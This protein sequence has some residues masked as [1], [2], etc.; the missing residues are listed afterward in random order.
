MGALAGTLAA[1]AAA[2]AAT[3][4]VIAGPPVTERP[5]GLPRDAD[6]NAFYR[7]NVTIHVGDRVR[8]EI[9][10]FHTVTIPARGS[11][12][13]GFIVPDPANPVSG[14]NDAG[15]SPFW[16]NGLPRLVVNPLV[17]AKQGGGTY[18]GRRL[19]N[20]GLPPQEGRTPPYVVRFPQRGTFRY[21]CAIHTGNPD[22]RGTVRVV[23]KRRAIPSAAEDRAAA[24][25]QFRRALARLRTDARFRGPSGNRVA[26][27]VDTTNTTLLRFR[28]AVK[29]VR[30]G[31]TLTFSMSAL[32]RA[33]IAPA[34]DGA[35]LLN[36]IA[37]F[38]SEPPPV[39]P[40]FQGTEHGNGYFNTGLIDRDPR[41]PSG[42]SARVTFARPGT[43][44][45]ICL[46]HPDTMKAQ[47][48]V[49]P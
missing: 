49:T 19:L 2:E 24:R 37:G 10:G 48:V 17:G 39:L 7:R 6:T 21:L 35:L 46:L 34:P 33:L 26:A 1:S 42:P 20:S 38:P 11:R 9:R 23:G 31:T 29:T 4:T 13:P 36:P 22:M 18:T 43:Y 30:A 3:K 12:P 14:V 8:W 27:G 15:G 32:A 25:R 28:P 41:S 40:P 16:F 5:P 44:G 45:Y 47:V